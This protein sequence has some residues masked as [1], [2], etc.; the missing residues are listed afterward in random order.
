MN[1]L[2]ISIISEIDGDRQV[3]T[4]DIKEEDMI[5]IMDKYGSCGCSVRGNI[6]DI[7]DEIADIW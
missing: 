7:I 1:Y 4:F 6:N 3:W 5:A 2:P